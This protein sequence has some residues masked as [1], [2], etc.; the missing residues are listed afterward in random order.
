MEAGHAEDRGEVPDLPVVKKYLSS[1]TVPGTPGEVQNAIARSLNTHINKEL[2]F[3]FFVCSDKAAFRFKVVVAGKTLVSDFA[4]KP[5]YLIPHLNCRQHCQFH[6]RFGGFGGEIVERTATL[7]AVGSHI[8]LPSVLA[9][10]GA[11][12]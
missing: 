1:H 3:V 10:F 9:G 12:I 7:V 11:V 8:V 4:D 2:T 5:G 6:Q